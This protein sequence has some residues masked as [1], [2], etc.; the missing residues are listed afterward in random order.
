[1]CGENVFCIAASEVGVFM[2]EYSDK[3]VQ[4]PNGRRYRRCLVDRSECEM[5]S[6]SERVFT[7]P[8]EH[9]IAPATVLR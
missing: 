6:S 1:M 2:I 5:I 4:A 3:R 8:V 7:H 9:G